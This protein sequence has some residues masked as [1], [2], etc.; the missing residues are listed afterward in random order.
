MDSKEMVE[1]RGESNALLFSNGG[2]TQVMKNGINKGIS[3]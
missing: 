3:C 2:I 1:E